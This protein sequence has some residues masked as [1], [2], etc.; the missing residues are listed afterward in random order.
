M[1]IPRHEMTKELTKAHET[2]EK[3]VENNR[4]RKIEMER[5]EKIEQIERDNPNFL[6]MDYAPNKFIIHQKKSNS[7]PSTMSA[8]VTILKRLG[9]DSKIIIKSTDLWLLAEQTEKSRELQTKQA[10]EVR[11]SNPDYDVVYHTPALQNSDPDLN[12][13]IFLPIEIL[14]KRESFEK[15]GR[16]V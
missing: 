7:I 4:K 10:Q 12:S 1:A 13:K 2:I 8:N 11:I 6:V 14:K 5:R 15:R 16:E 3:A 9:Y